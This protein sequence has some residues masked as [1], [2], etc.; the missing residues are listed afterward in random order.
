MDE[1]VQTFRVNAQHPVVS[2]KLRAT[3][4]PACSASW[5]VSNASLSNIFL[6][7]LFQI[8]PV[9]HVMVGGNMDLL[10]LEM[11]QHLRSKTPMMSCSNVIIHQF[12]DSRMNS[13][14]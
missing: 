2:F 11:F 1:N 4:A 3:G 5:D 7:F 12:L 10:K 14:G 13:A 8:C 9:I 6:Q